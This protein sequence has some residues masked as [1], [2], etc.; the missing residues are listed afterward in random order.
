[1]SW[2]SFGQVMGLTF[3]I[4]MLIIWVQHAC[5]DKVRESAIKRKEAGL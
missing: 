1:M 5:V 2:V 3:W 4:A